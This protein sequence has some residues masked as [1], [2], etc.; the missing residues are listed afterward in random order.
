[1]LLAQG[2]EIACEPTPPNP[3]GWFYGNTDNPQPGH[4][5]PRTS[6]AQC[7]TNCKEW[8]AA[9]G[10]PDTRYTCQRHSRSEECYTP[11]KEKIIYPKN[12]FGCDWCQV[13]DCTTGVL[14]TQCNDGVDNGVD[15]KFDFC[16]TDGSNSGTCDSDCDSVTDDTEES[17][18]SNG[19]DDEVDGTRDFLV[20][21]SQPSSTTESFLNEESL[22]GE[23][24]VHINKATA[25]GSGHTISVKN[26]NGIL[27]YRGRDVKGG[28]RTD[29]TN[30]CEDSVSTSKKGSTFTFQG[31]DI[32]QLY[33][34]DSSNSVIGTVSLNKTGNYYPIPDGTSKITSNTIQPSVSGG[35]PYGSIWDG[36]SGGSCTFDII[37]DE[38]PTTECNDGI[39]NN[40][41]DTLIDFPDDPGCDSAND[42]SEYLHDLNCD[43][44][45][46]DDESGLPPVP[47]LCD[48]NQTILII[49]SDGSFLPPIDT[50]SGTRIC[51]DYIF[52]VTNNDLTDALTCTGQNVV[53][54]VNSTSGLASIPGTP[55]SDLTDLCFDSLICNSRPSNVACEADEFTTVKLSAETEGTLGNATSMLPTQICCRV[56]DPGLNRAYWADATG[57]NVINSASLASFVNLVVEGVDI[58]NKLMT[59]RIFKKEALFGIDFFFPDKLIATGS[60]TGSS[61][62]LAGK[63]DD[64]TFDGEEE[65]YFEANI[66]SLN[67][68]VSTLDN[69]DTDYRYLEVSNERF[70][71]PPVAVI[72]FPENKQIYFI[73][74]QIYFEQGSFDIDSGFFNYTWELGD[75]TTLSG[76]SDTFEN[77]NFNY[78]YHSEENL[79]QQNIKLSVEDDQGALD[80]AR[81]SILVI[82]S[83]YILAFVDEPLSGVTYGRTVDFDATSTY[84]VSSET[85]VAAD[86]T[87]TKEITCEGGNCPGGTIGCPSSASLG[88]NFDPATCPILVANAPSSPSAAN[89]DAIEFNWT[90]RNDHGYEENKS[91]RGISNAL[92]T[93]IFPSADFYVT[94]LKASIN[95]SSTTKIDFAVDFSPPTC[96]AD[97]TLEQANA[98]TNI[99]F[100]ESYWSED[101]SINNAMDSCIRA[102]GVNEDGEAR[103]QCCPSG[104]TCSDDGR[105]VVAILT[106]CEEYDVDT[107]EEDDGHPGEASS[108]L[109]DVPGFLGCSYSPKFGD[110]CRQYIDC[111]CSWNSDDNVCEAVSDHKIEKI[112]TRESWNYASP[113]ANINSICDT[114]EE[115]TLDTCSFVFS[116]TGSC[117]DGDEF[118]TKSWTAERKNNAASFSDLDYCSPGS[119]IIACERVIRL[120]FFSLQ[121]II[122]T[123]LIIGLIYYWRIHKKTSRRGKR[124]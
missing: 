80:S 122:V 108:E 88:C 8:I 44:L 82:N 28:A 77:Y 12:H 38:G 5:G 86:G 31:I 10:E 121:N 39:N 1:M 66:S 27:Y 54:K 50:S 119:E 19:I 65:Y 14:I 96:F 48:L 103:T 115:A 35:G 112:S 105:C 70:N 29:Y 97:I 2:F 59:F 45:E 87:C 67:I 22:P 120:P 41:G 47:P 58:Q 85:I 9:N 99:N 107:C 37:I 100:G 40:D 118:I 91:G 63:I 72:N 34:K 81:I 60:Q 83:T 62:W 73:D 69:A 71:N 84:S 114:P 61:S 55:G 90:F 18:C 94:S 98:F 74:S 76:D 11:V 16:E 116:Y 52:G 20:T 123:I 113:P 17:Q 23:E 42:N 7:L 57:N 21:I 26:L 32:T 102:D 51:Y 110:E 75:G 92:F 95:P 15:G 56:A 30:R 93:Q 43:S 33:F 117:L 36:W 104:S 79:G 109:E 89:F 101:D 46:D 3:A 64:T 111:R 6:A 68:E 53:L 78:T 25:Y 106:G 24:T 49:D 124:K 13:Q 4:G